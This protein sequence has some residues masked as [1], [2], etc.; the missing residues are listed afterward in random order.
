MK[1]NTYVMALI[2]IYENNGEDKKTVYRVLSCV[3]YTLIDNYVCIDYLLCQSKTWCEILRNPTFKETSF[4]LLRG[5]GITELLLNLVSC[6]GFMEKSNST[7]VLNC[8][9]NLINNYLSKRLF[10]IEQDSNKLSLIL[11]DVI[12]RINVVYQL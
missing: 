7:V 10:I 9:S 8:R 5:I 1:K 4:N 2:I 6:H 11:N 3:V 12:L